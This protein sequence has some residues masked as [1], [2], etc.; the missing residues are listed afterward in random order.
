[1]TLFI[2]STGASSTGRVPYAKQ[3]VSEARQR[4][5]RHLDQELQRLYSNPA[6][7]DP[8]PKIKCSSDMEMVIRRASSNLDIYGNTD[9]YAALTK[10]EKNGGAMYT[11]KSP[12]PQGQQRYVTMPRKQQYVANAAAYRQYQQSSGRQGGHVP[13]PVYINKM[14]ANSSS[15]IYDQVYSTLPSG[16]ALRRLATGVHGNSVYGRHDV[17]HFQTSERE[18][19]ENSR[20]LDKRTVSDKC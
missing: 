9:L 16:K 11:F 6:H 1:M 18:N 14:R 12:V 5:A 8:G 10:G 19:I 17:S 2:F 3:T 15:C 7:Q 20:L 4:S 13:E